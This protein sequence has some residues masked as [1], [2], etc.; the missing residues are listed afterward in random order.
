MSFKC[1]VPANLVCAASEALFSFR[2][3]SSRAAEPKIPKTLLREAGDSEEIVV[4][5]FGPRRGRSWPVSGQHSS[6]RTEA[7]ARRGAEGLDE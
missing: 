6:G 3:G 1:L 2:A 7:V 5:V 4:C